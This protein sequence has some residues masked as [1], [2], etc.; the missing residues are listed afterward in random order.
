MTISISDIRPFS[1]A[2]AAF[3]KV[4]EDCISGREI[5]VTKNGKPV[6]AVINVR[7]LQ[8]YHQLEQEAEKLVQLVNGKETL[9]SEKHGSYDLRQQYF[10]T[11]SDFLKSANDVDAVTLA[12]T[13]NI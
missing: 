4:V 11:F 6:V 7:Q 10:S 9:G 13:P 1:D 8:W 12:S 5:I 3:S 2:R